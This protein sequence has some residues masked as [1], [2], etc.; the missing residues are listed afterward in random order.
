M[1]C[2][3]GVDLAHSPRVV[4]QRDEPCRVMGG[5]GPLIEPVS[6]PAESVRCYLKRTRA[7]ACF[8]TAVIRR[9]M[10]TGVWIWLGKTLLSEVIGCSRP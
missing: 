9:T 1:V 7:N 8:I 2:A 5:I 6:I 4:S 10:P 3:Q